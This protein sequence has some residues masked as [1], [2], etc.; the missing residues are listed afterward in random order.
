M[1]LAA[2]AVESEYTSFTVRNAVNNSRLEAID[3]EGC[4]K[5]VAACRNTM[6][7]ELT[8]MGV[9]QRGQAY[10]RR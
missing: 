7:R 3:G 10:V 9:S 4:R 2:N 5:L 6:A 1:C 8:V